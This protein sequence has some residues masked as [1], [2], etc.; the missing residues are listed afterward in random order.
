M[1][2][3]IIVGAGLSGGILARKLAEEKKKK[4][5]IIERRNHIAGN[6]YDYKDEHGVLVQKYGPHTFH[7]NDDFVY[8]FIMQYADAIPYKTKCE[9]VV[10][11]ISTPSPFNFKTID[12][13]YNEEEGNELKK[14][15]LEYYDN[16]PY[17]TVVEMLESMN[18]KIKVFAQFL[19][20]NDYK[21]YT[22]KQWNLDPGEI[23][24]SVLKRVPI[25]LS[26]RDTYFDDKYEF[27]PKDGFTEF[28]KKLVDY[29]GID[30]VLNDDALKHIEVEDDEK[31][32]KYD[33]QVV[34]VIYTGAID[35]LFNYKYGVLPYRSL[36]FD[37][38]SEKRSSTED[39]GYQNAAIVAYPQADGY[40]RIT[41]FTKMP[42]Q[43][44]E[45]TTYAVEYPKAYDRNAEVGN[46][47]YYP[48]L[49]K[50]SE[51]RYEQYK[52]Y[53]NEFSNLTLCGRLA[54]FKY[55]N[56]DQVVLRAL[57][58]YDSIALKCE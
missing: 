50:D 49:T 42:Y 43:N 48:V 28:Y 5:L 45:W 8:Q 38:K 33:G 35:E 19:F 24:P 1:Y 41:E 13:F 4:V 29:P 58:V 30:I 54:D 39:S 23:D 17:V 27:Q 11:G 15:L 10:N 56:M 20:N 55:Y 47:P 18:D 52:S 12:Q 32:V 16:R 53:A 25:V 21:L 51:R 57:H 3:Y 37:F 9:A 2:D 7:T 44:T 26:Y 46:E 36:W 40:T 22:A 14:D 6:T 34:P 31:V